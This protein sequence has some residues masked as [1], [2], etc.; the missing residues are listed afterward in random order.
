MAATGG[1]KG[2]Y[3]SFRLGTVEYGIDILKVQEIRGYEVPTRIAN[4]SAYLLGVLN[5]RGV[6]VPILDLRLK[7]GQVQA[8]FD[9]AT[10]T[11]VLNLERGMVGAVV[12]AVNDVV[13]LSPAQILPTPAVGGP[14][15]D[16]FIYGIGALQNGEQERTLVMLDIEKLMRQTLDQRAAQILQ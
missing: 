9:H 1:P 11:V 13:E 7:L 16:S 4:A 2:E 3:L 12:D 6:I 5:L 15:E 14:A 10:V 8:G